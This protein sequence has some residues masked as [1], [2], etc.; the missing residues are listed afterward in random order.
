[1]ENDKNCIE[2]S[3]SSSTVTIN[4]DETVGDICKEL[5]AQGINSDTFK[6]N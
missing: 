3:I 6:L 2:I 4:I 1:M 5:K